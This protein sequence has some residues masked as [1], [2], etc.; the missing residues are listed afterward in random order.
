MPRPRNRVPS[1]PRTVYLPHDLEAKVT[2]LLMS[3]SRGKPKQGAWSDLVTALLREW[4]ARQIREAQNV[5][6]Q[7]P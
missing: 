4:L 3:A 1:K 7:N 6:A 2:L 5:D